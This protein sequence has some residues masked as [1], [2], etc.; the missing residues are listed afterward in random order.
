[1]RDEAKT[2]RNSAVVSLVSS[3][4]SA[5][6]EVGT[7]AA[8]SRFSMKSA[9]AMNVEEEPSLIEM[10]RRILSDQWSLPPAGRTNQQ[11]PDFR[12]CTMS[13]PL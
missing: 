13:R 5:V 9:K 3:V 2:I 11:R 8:S 7:A 1:M 4:C 12:K 10:A 6:V